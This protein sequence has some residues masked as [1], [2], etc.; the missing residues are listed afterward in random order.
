M[1][2]TEHYGHG[3]SQNIDE[4]YRLISYEK[5]KGVV[6]G[7]KF[8]ES[9]N[10][11]SKSIKIDELKNAFYVTTKV[12]YKGGR[13]LVESNS[14][15]GFVTLK[16]ND[17]LVFEKMGLEI[18]KVNDEKEMSEVELYKKKYF[19]VFDGFIVRVAIDEIKE[20]WEERTKSEFDL[21]MPEGIEKTKIIYQNDIS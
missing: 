15:I 13:F 5:S 9:N 18:Y 16:T 4:N 10:T 7:F 8:E 1:S 17:S 2:I 3:L 12:L 20:F 21:P 19:K 14:Q 11:F 6:G